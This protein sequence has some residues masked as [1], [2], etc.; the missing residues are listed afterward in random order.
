MGNDQI[1]LWD[2]DSNATVSLS[3]SKNDLIQKIMTTYLIGGHIIVRPAELFEGEDFYFDDAVSENG[4]LYNLMKNGEASLALDINSSIEERVSWRFRNGNVFDRGKRYDNKKDINKIRERTEK[5]AEKLI[6]AG[7]KSCTK[8][9]HRSKMRYESDLNIIS[10]NY[11][12]IVSTKYFGDINKDSFINLFING[13]SQITSRSDLYDEIKNKWSNDVNENEKNNFISDCKNVLTFASIANTAKNYTNRISEICDLNYNLLSTYS[14][15]S[16]FSVSQIE[17]T[18]IRSFL[19]KM[20][21]Y[22]FKKDNFSESVLKMNAKKFVEVSISNISSR[23][24]DEIHQLLYGESKHFNGLNISQVVYQE[25][26]KSGIVD[27]DSIVEI[28]VD[29]LSNVYNNKTGRS[30]ILYSLLR[31]LG[32]EILLLSMGNPIPIF[33]TLLNS[34]IDYAELKES[35]KHFFSGFRSKI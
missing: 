28:R 12:S 32:L 4:F 10:K 29:E 11:L 33:P 15:Q 25:A 7:W 24:R 21:K 31:S 19:K 16:K 1:L 35:Q 34:T 3:T 20:A 6:K 22:A 18:I 8:Q 5:R 26:Q 2:T 14:S 30:T 23:D 27:I 13:S 17:R 9:T